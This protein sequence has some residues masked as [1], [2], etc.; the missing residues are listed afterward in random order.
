[1]CAELRQIEFVVRV[2]I[3]AASLCK[4]RRPALVTRNFKNCCEDCRR[5]RKWC[6]RHM[7]FRRFRFLSALFQINGNSGKD[8]GQSRRVVEHKGS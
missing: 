1:M 6:S 8:S 5:F 2:R 4:S 7:D 3:Q